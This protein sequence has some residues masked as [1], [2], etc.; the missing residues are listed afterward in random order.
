MRTPI[1]RIATDGAGAPLDDVALQRRAKVLGIAAV[2][3]FAAL[4]LHDAPLKPESPLG[5]VSLQLAGTAE[6][7]AGIV[8]AFSQTQRLLCAFGLGVDYFFM[9]LYPTAVVAGLAVVARRRPHAARAV[10]AVSWGL[11]LCGFVD[12][13]ENAALMAVL[14]GASVYAPI[15]AG[16]AIIKFTTLSVGLG[17]LVGLGARRS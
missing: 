8:A 16:C 2:S 4:A 6:A 14:L 3:V 13:I 15:A 9:A 7:A 5:I 11:V 1:E 12:V 10:A 17:A